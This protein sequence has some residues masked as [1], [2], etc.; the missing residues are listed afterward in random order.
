MAEVDLKDVTK[1]YGGVE[2]VSG[3][4]LRI[5]DGKF[6]VLVGPSGCGK[7]TTLRMIA[8]LEEVSEGSIRLDERDVTDLEPKDRDVAMVFQNYALYPHMSIYDNIAFGLRARKVPKAD[9]DERVRRAAAM[10]GIEHLLKRKPRAL[11]GGQQQR[12]AIG[13]AMV[14]EPAAFLFDEPLSNLDAKLRVE[15]RDEL[16]RVHK[17]LGTTVVY[18]THDQEE[19]MT[20][21]DLMVVMRD[22]EIVQLGTPYEV[23]S[24]PEHEFVGRFVG[25][26]EMNV[27]EGT[28]ERG[29]FR[30]KNVSVPVPAW[31]SGPVKLGVRP[32]DVH[33]SEE[34]AGEGESS[35]PMEARVELVELL[36]G[37]AVVSLLLR[38]GN[39][40]AV[41]EARVLEGLREGGE[42][43]V[44]FDLNRLHFFDARTGKRLDGPIGTGA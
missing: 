18:V 22:G 32:E 21:S 35:E 6:V 42:T 2:A 23:Y 27:L 8:G 17:R 5:P 15:M 26:P 36:G 1:R 13:R 14:R 31:L 20:L 9:M 38:G 44:S 4:N 19:A 34:P 25:S 28:A 29:V 16:L 43:R 24:R 3:I 40:K 10:R 37:R 41:V 33:T 30:S 7:T 11:S 12:V 39:I